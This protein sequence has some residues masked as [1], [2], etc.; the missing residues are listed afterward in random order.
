MGKLAWRAGGAAAGVSDEQ[1]EFV[2]VERSMPVH[3]AAVEALRD[4]MADLLVQKQSWGDLS[5]QFLKVEASMLPSV[6]LCGGTDVSWFVAGIK[7]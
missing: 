1:R 2:R 7:G 6:A 3:A 5:V 4:S